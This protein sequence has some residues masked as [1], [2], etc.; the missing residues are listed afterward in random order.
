MRQINGPSRR[1]VVAMVSGVSATVLAGLPER[2]AAQVTV[3]WSSGT[4]LPTTKVLAN[5]TDCHHHI[6]DARFPPDPNSVLRPGDA[7]VADYRQLQKRIGTSRNIVVQPSTYGIDNSLL[8]AALKEFG[9]SARGVCVVNTGVTDAELQNLHDGGV[10]GIRFN[11][12]TP[13]GA[14]SFE[15]VEPLSKRAAALGWHLQFYVSADQIVQRKDLFGNLPCPV[16]FD[17]MARLTDPGHAAFPIVV[18]LLKKGKAW[19]K[20]SGAY[21]ET[22]VGPPTYADRSAVAQ[23]FV[24]EAPDRLVWGSDWPH[25]T[26]KLDNKPNDALLLDL[27]AQWAPDATTRARILVDNPARLYGF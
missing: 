12:V 26:E 25:P 17:H 23:A 3:K 24:R 2:A 7:T 1:S 4:D 19:V 18:D 27:L 11:I 22:K 10:R 15:M 6:Y 8:L 14:T 20:L 13:G 9:P 16:V 21:I 5:A